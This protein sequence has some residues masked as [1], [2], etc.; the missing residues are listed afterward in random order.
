MRRSYIWALLI[1]VGIGGWLASG[2]IIIGGQGDTTAEA[3]TGETA[4][5][6]TT[7]IASEAKAEEKP[8]RVRVRTIHA[9]DRTAQ[10][11]IRGRTEA[12]QRVVLRAQTPGLV[13][14]IGVK[15]GD[16]VAT[17]DLVC[18][19]E[20]GSR[21]STILR[22]EAGLAQAELDHQAA[23]K[24]SE[25]GYAAET[26]VRSTKAALHAARAV[27][28]EA[29]LDMDRT[30]LTAPF[31]GIVDTLPAKIG[32]LLNVGDVCAEIIDADPM[33]VI[34]QVSER[35]VGRIETGM[36]GSAQL[37]TGDT[38]DGYL[39]FIAPSADEGTRTFRIE[40]SVAN[41]DGKL[42]DGVTSEI[43]I[44][45]ETTKAHRF[46]PAILTLDDLGNIG[47]RAVD[48]DNKVVFMPVTLLDN[49]RDGV[50]V[51]GLPETVT[52]ITVGQDYVKAGEIVEPVFETASKTSQTGSVTQ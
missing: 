8:F 34:A 7:D 24:L 44:P 49:D 19:L 38:A 30:S 6:P 23:T 14:A 29:Q 20:K 21:A 50:W 31:N 22:A 13:E 33:L 5:E 2:Q 12:A 27:L 41:P 46:S 10:L 39:R 51:A 42:R 36:Q 26:R 4:V 48:K 3:S 25:K 1:T 47:V 15:K 11:K 40:L 28:A 9:E 43:T 16:H 35:D 52:V 18:R 45:L 32:T 17:G 37:V